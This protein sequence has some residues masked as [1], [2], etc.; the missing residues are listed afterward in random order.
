MAAVRRPLPGGREAGQ[1][2]GDGAS[3]GV[4]VGRAD[5]KDKAARG[6]EGWVVR[7]GTTGR[8]T[9]EEEGGVLVSPRDPESPGPPNTAAGERG[10]GPH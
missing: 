4:Q 1:G 3:T 5:T 8:E 6:A 10:R 2:G 9:A 7:F